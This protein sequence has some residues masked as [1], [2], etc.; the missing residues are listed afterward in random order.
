MTIG[1]IHTFT[2]V[3]NKSFYINGPR[4]SAVV[5]TEVSESPFNIGHFVNLKIKP[6][7]SLEIRVNFHPHS[8]RY[9]VQLHRGTLWGFFLQEI[10]RVGR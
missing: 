9:R 8:V 5:E 4:A 3:P 2:T 7:K 1:T 10:E 6:G